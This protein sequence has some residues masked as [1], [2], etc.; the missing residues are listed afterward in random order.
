MAEVLPATPDAAPEMVTADVELKTADWRMST[1]VTVPKGR[2]PLRQVLPLAQALTDAVVDVA[3]RASEQR[4]APISCKKG[5]GACCRQLVPITETEAHELR[6]LVENMPEPRRSVIRARFADARR[7]L[8]AAGLLPALEQP[9]GWEQPDFRALGLDYFRQ[10]IACPFL[11]DES[12]SIYADR[13]VTCRDY[14]VTSAAENCARPTAE[15]VHSVAMPVKVMWA[16][17][18]LDPVPP[19]ARY[20]RWVPLIL[21]PS[22]AEAHPEEPEPRP[23]PDWLRDLFHH[24]SANAQERAAT[25]QPARGAEFEV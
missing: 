25:D 23:G 5:C 19:G 22:W 13:P 18:R 24:L 1:R 8:E 12:C 9:Q 4:G 16:L 17:A 14:V 15:T 2:I 10:A 7:R 11:E 3:I 6:D 20:V 21:A